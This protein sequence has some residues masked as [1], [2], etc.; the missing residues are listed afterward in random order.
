MNKHWRMVVG[1]KN[2]EDEDEWVEDSW[3]GIHPEQ[4]IENFNKSLRPGE[5]PRI[6]I[7]AMELEERDKPHDW[8]KTNLVTKM[9]KTGQYDSYKCSICGVTGKRR[10]LGGYV[11]Q[12]KKYKASKYQFCRNNN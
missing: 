6:L 11:T 12:D 3:L 8:A 10:S 5:R 2:G 1:Y 9:D 7:A 4:V